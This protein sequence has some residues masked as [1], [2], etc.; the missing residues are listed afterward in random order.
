MAKETATENE[1]V[2]K[3]GG[4]SRTERYAKH[5]QNKTQLVFPDLSY[6]WYPEAIKFSIVERGG[7]SM[8]K[9]VKAAKQAYKESSFANLQEVNKEIDKVT[10]QVSNL[11]T[12]SN[13]ISE[14]LKAAQGNLAKLKEQRTK[15]QNDSAG[16]Q[17]WEAGKKIANNIAEQNKTIQPKYGSANEVRSIYLNMPN[18]LPA[19]DEKVEWGGSDM[20]IIGAFMGGGGGAGLASGAMANI[21]ELASGGMGAAIGKMFGGGI[22]GGVLAGA[23]GGESL[24]KLAE[25]KTGTLQNPFKEQTFNGIGFRMFSF[26]FV[27]RARDQSDVNT[28][29]EI[30]DSFRAYSKPTFKDYGS[31]TTFKYPHEF[32]IEFL[33]LSGEGDASQYTTNTHLPAIKYCICDNVSTNFAEESWKAFDGGAPVEIKLALSFQETEIVTQ[34]DVLGTTK[35]GRFADKGRKF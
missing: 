15:L 35:V 34:E 25:H 17:V 4:L 1:N 6:E 5:V 18:A 29:R 3:W 32:H 14:K 23:L 27:F 22:A 20:G 9:V 12:P 19:F 16:R 26:N 31:S 8:D 30:I 13:V 10:E 7:I 24:Q 28:I 21:G 33:K 2:Q 11:T